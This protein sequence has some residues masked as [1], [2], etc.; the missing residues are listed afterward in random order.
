MIKQRS[1]IEIEVKGRE[2]R[3]ECPSESTWQE[4]IAALTIM[5]EFSQE[6]IRA[7]APQTDETQESAQ[8]HCA[9]E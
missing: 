5:Y 9:K 4:V 3:F 6:R 2:F 1:I 7:L 8:D